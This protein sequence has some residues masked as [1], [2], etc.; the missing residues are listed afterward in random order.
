MV[1]L[2][3]VNRESSRPAWAPVDT[4]TVLGMGKRE[5]SHEGRGRERKFGFLLNDTPDAQVISVALPLWNSSLKAKGKRVGTQSQTVCLV[6]EHI[7]DRAGVLAK[8]R[9]K[10]ITQALSADTVF[11]A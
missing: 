8:A 4:D 6:T 10:A 2:K 7:P 3:E 1:G 9:E 5:K 11:Q